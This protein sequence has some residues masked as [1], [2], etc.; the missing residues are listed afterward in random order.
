MHYLSPK[1]QMFVLRD[2]CCKVRP[3][4]DLGT[5]DPERPHTV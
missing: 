2:G 4:V 5:S 1:V 3:A